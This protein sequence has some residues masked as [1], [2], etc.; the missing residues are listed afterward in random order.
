VLCVLLAFS[1]SYLF[2]KETFWVLLFFLPELQKSRP[3]VMPHVRV[4]F[5]LDLVRVV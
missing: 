5:C 3:I 2:I 1:H 4:I